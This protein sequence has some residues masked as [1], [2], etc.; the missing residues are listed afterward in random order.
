M[1]AF[2]GCSVEAKTFR[3]PVVLIRIVYVK[4][5]STCTLPGVTQDVSAVG[6]CTLVRGAVNTKRPNYIVVYY[7]LVP[8]SNDLCCTLF[9]IQSRISTKN[10][11]PVVFVLNIGV[12]LFHLHP[13]KRRQDVETNVAAC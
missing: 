2:R 12:T 10:I 3:A 13:C 7:T 11:L 1:G 5:A 4:R 8:V 9:V 6:V